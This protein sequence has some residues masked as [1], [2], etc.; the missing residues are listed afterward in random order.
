[1]KEKD[2]KA[3]GSSTS[4][5]QERKHERTMATLKIEELAAAPWNPREAITAKSVKD[6]AG[7]IKALGVIQPLIVMRGA[8][9]YTIIAGHRRLVAAK[10]AGLGEVPCE[11][12]EGVDEATAKRMTFIENLQRKDAD[13][14]LEAELIE[15]LVENGMTEEEIAA[16][17]G[18][19]LKWVRR[20][21]N[22][23]RLSKGWR[24]LVKERGGFTVDCLE[25]VAAY[26][27]E[28]QE[29]VCKKTRDYL[30]SRWPDIASYFRYETKEL[31]EAKFNKAACRACPY[32]SGFSPDLFDWSNGAQKYGRCM[33]EKCFREKNAKY[34]EREIEKAEKAGAKVEKSATEP[35][36]YWKLAD[37]RDEKHPVLY[38]WGLD[39]MAQAKW[40]PE[41][42]EPGSGR[43]QDGAQERAEREEKRVKNKARRKLAAW[44]KAGK[45]GDGGLAAVLK[46]RYP[47]G[48][49]LKTIMM[50]QNAFDIRPTGYRVLGT[51]EGIERANRAILARE[52]LGL[53]CP[54]DVGEEK[55]DEWSQT[56]AEAI[57]KEIERD[58]LG[59]KAAQLALAIFGPK[60]R[61]ALS[62]E[63]LKKLA[64]E[65]DGIL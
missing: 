9:G 6:L 37:K 40:G 1:M 5:H 49:D 17:T 39:G 61:G 31:D 26:P 43:A 36:E 64:G 20:R 46:E 21:K 60:A 27:E 63:E 54:N 52:W 30:Y 2:R 51:E 24:A 35:K 3:D 25:R 14:L 57:G 38:A 32:N 7:S 8:E 59:E 62:E 22:L 56:A 19:G 29:K 41:K 12:I 16:E 13:P 28:I 10:A 65:E 55:M 18:N 33:N 53:K 42:E 45:D 23:T 44:C 47:S 48:V 58:Y 50:L 34:V 15:G 11:I 4:G